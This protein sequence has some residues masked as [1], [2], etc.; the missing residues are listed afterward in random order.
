LGALGRAFWAVTALGVVFTLARFSEAFLVLRVEGVGLPLIW[1]P[2]VLVVMNLVYALVAYPAGSLSDRID[3]RVVLAA[4]LGA[5]IAAD[6]VLALAANVFAALAGV[7]LWGLH[8]GLTQGLLAALVADTA[9]PARRGTAFGWFNL[10]SGVAL[11][12]AS[13][14][15]GALWEVVGPAATFYAGAAFAA[16]ALGGLLAW[17]ARRGAA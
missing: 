13:L 14:L 12:F 2:L 10:V 8:L 17:L 3:R 9:P 1:V 15:A 11:L 7:A 5:L 6:I 4:G 16:L